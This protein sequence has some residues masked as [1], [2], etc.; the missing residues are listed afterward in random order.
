MRALRDFLIIATVTLGLLEIGLRIYNPIY[1]PL[2]AD[3]IELPVNR[4]FKATNVNNKKVDRDRVTRYNALGLRGPDYPADP[5]QFIKIFAVGG[6]TTAC[7]TLTDGKTWPDVLG[8]LL[9]AGAGKGVWINNAGIDGHSTFGHQ[10]L[11]ESHLRKY[12]ADFIVFLIGV[13]DV[14]RDD[15]NDYDTRLLERGLSWRNRMVAASELLST[16]QVLRRAWRAHDTGLNHAFD[17]DLTRLERGAE[18]PEQF[19]AQLQRHRDGHLVRYRQR[20]ELLLETTS[21][22]GARPVL[23]TQPA[24]YG[25]GRDPTTGVDL[26]PLRWK[27][28]N[29]PT[30]ALKWAELDLYNDVLRDLAR[31]QG[32]VLIDAARSMPKDSKYYFD[33]IHYSNEGAALMAQI[34]QEGLQPHLRPGAK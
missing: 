2:R 18:T 26:G 21:R 10:V 1:V 29:G 33:W 12:P 31:R 25:V 4:V 6:S 16:A 22:L 34:V 13:N 9:D 28:D 27:D 5:Q 7:V 20:V 3:R 30:A 11:L 32:V 15:L 19:D 17:M 8:K 24:L 14:G 23:V